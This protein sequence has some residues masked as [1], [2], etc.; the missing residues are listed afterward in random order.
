[1]RRIAAVAMIA[2]ATAGC[3]GSSNS[4]APSS[5]T[6]ASTSQVVGTLPPRT[7]LLI[8]YAVPTCPPGARC[9]LTSP[10]GQD[11]YYI[12][13]RR[14]TCS[15]DGGDYDDPTAACRA[16]ADLVTKLDANPTPAVV[17]DCFALHN[18]PKAVGIHNGE[19]RTIPLDGCSLCGLQGIG[20]DLKLL[21]P[22]AG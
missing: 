13:S 15:P 14:L 18:P 11:D 6:G 2:L 10:A 17:C 3:I 7:N 19:R 21:L 1:M 5:T 12:M 4:S 8:T 20:G 22:N 16:L 9:V